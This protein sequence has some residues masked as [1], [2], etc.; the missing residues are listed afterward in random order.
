MVFTAIPSGK[1]HRHCFGHNDNRIRCAGKI[2]PNSTRQAPIRLRLA[3]LDWT[4]GSGEKAEGTAGRPLGEA[5]KSYCRAKN[6]DSPW[7]SG[8]APDLFGYFGLP[9]D[10]EPPTE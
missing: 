10:A 8:I 6:R 3:E 9:Y 5:A 1:R 2:R 4:V 7:I